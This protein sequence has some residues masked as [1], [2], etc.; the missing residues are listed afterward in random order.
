VN[1]LGFGRAQLALSRFQGCL[2]SV[3]LRRCGEILA[4]SIIH[5]LLR[6]DSRLALKDSVQTGVLQ[7]QRLILCFVAG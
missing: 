7:V 3:H 5:F 6:H 2:A 1:Q 4:L